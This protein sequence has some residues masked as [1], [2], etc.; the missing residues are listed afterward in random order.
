MNCNI[1]ESELERMSAEESQYCSEMAEYRLGM[2]AE[3]PVDIYNPK[4]QEKVVGHIGDRRGRKT[5]AEAEFQRQLRS[6]YLPD[7]VI[8][9]AVISDRPANGSHR[10]RV[11]F[12][13]KS[14]SLCYPGTYESEKVKGIKIEFMTLINNEI[15]RRQDEKQRRGVAA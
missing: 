11:V 6:F 3:P 15:L 10:R 2:R 14:K 13:Y 12:P 5:R 7:T 9:T 8:N 1:K 4:P